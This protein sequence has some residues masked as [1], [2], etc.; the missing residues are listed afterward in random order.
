MIASVL[1]CSLPS[2]ALG[3]VRESRV[4]LQHQTLTPDL[5]NMTSSNP[6]GAT[7]ARSLLELTAH[8]APDTTLVNDPAV[9][10]QAVNL[11]THV[12]PATGSEETELSLTPQQVQSSQQG[13]D[14]N[15]IM[16]LAAVAGQ[17]QNGCPDEYVSMNRGE[18]MCVK[19]PHVGAMTM[20]LMV[21]LFVAACMFG[22]FAT[23]GNKLRNPKDES[24]TMGGE[25]EVEG[26][27]EEE[28][29]AYE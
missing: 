29:E 13:A 28:E 11:A 22:I 3:K 27:E 24:E 16:A 19:Q 1:F 8:T 25:F 21:G 6:A 23:I 2:V 5:Q 12:S 20:I 10:G 14:Y 26:E 15:N 17:T 4:F 9:G 7:N 18:W